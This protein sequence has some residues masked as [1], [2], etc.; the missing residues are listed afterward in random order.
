MLLVLDF[1]CKSHIYG[2]FSYTNRRQK[3]K[4]TPTVT[5]VINLSIKLLSRHRLSSQTAQVFIKFSPNI[6]RVGGSLRAVKTIDFANITS[7]KN[8]KHTLVFRPHIL[9]CLLLIYFKKTYFTWQI[10]T[11]F[12]NSVLKY[13]SLSYLLL[14][15]PNKFILGQHHMGSRHHLVVSILSIICSFHKEP[16]VWLVWKVLGRRAA[17]LHFHGSLELTGFSSVK[18]L[19]IFI[20]FLHPLLVAITLRMFWSTN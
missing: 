5:Q 3:R 4:P 17:E 7:K 10:L 16:E 15:F 18:Q 12:L 14:F 11:F 2:H 6:C 20:N 13:S 19:H 9:V 1:F 8:K